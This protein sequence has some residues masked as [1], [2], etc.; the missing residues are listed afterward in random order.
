MRRPSNEVRGYGNGA[1][2]IALM[3]SGWALIGLY[4]H[5]VALVCILSI[6][7]LLIALGIKFIRTGNRL[8][9]R[10]ALPTATEIAAERSLQK[11]FIWIFAGEGIAIFLAVNVLAKIGKSFFLIPTIGIIVGLHFLPLARVY[12]RPLFYWS[13]AVQIL[14]CVITGFVRRSDPAGLN[15]ITAL[16]M[17]II[18]WA[19]MFIVLMR[20]RTYTT[21]ARNPAEKLI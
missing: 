11:R 1:V 4:H 9:S 5:V 14:F 8:R 7:I 18:L 17:A 21:D 6:P 15:I 19:T 20:A 10:E 2:I 16:G 3:G 13:G 12:G